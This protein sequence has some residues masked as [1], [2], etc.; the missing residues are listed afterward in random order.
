MF[1]LVIRDFYSKVNANCDP[2]AK[3]VEIIFVSCNTTLEEHMENIAPM[4]FPMIPFDDPRIPILEENMDAASIPIVPLIRKN[5]TVARKNVRVLIQSQG[6]LCFPEL[7][8][9]A[10]EGI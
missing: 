6:A 5:G 1:E 2:N 8:K 4:P 9:A 10:N 7:L 3:N